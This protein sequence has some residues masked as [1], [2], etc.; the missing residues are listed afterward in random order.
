MTGPLQTCLSAPALPQ[1]QL[2]PHKRFLLPPQ[3]PRQRAQMALQL[4]LLGP[5]L[6][7]SPLPLLLLAELEVRASLLCLPSLTRRLRL[8]STTVSLQWV[9]AMQASTQKTCARQVYNASRGFMQLSWH[10]LLHCDCSNIGR[11]T[12]CLCVL[13]L[14][15]GCLA[16]VLWHWHITC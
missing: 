1:H 9:H 13:R 11:L 8:A 10:Q 15:L 3:L 14:Q 16:C 12:W 2:A 6:Q 7:P 5:A 4:P